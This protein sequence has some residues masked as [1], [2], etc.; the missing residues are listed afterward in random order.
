MILAVNR[1]YGRADYLPCISW[2]TIARETAAL[3][4]GSPMALVGRLQSRTYS[5]ALEDGCEERIAYEVSVMRPAE[6]QEF[7]VV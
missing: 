2:G 5:K 6:P 3:T 1:R 7:F 4:V